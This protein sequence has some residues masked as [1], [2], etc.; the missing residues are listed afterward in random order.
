M[1][2]STSEENENLGYTFVQDLPEFLAVNPIENLYIELRTAQYLNYKGRV[3][4]VSMWRF[5]RIS[6]S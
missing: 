5:C 3:A 2:A 1:G 6:K 4:S